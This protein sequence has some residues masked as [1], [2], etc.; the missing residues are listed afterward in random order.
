MQLWIDGKST[1]TTTYPLNL[2]VLLNE[3]L[4]PQ[5]LLLLPLLLLLLRLQT[6]TPAAATSTTTP[7]AADHTRLPLAP[8]PFAGGP[9]LVRNAESE[10]LTGESETPTV[11]SRTRDAR[12][13]EIPSSRVGNAAHVNQER[14]VEWETP[15]RG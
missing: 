8:W 13:S 11:E 1:M 3:L 7:T 15:F 2:H 12:E 10:T 4:L 5:L 14:D 6:T 9:G